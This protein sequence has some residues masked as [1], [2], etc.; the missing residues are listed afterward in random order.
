MISGGNNEKKILRWWRRRRW[1]RHIA[2]HCYVVGA[3]VL[4]PV[5]SIV[6]LAAPRIHILVVTSANAG[7]VLLSMCLSSVR[8][9]EFRA[10]ARFP[11]TVG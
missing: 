2:A 10:T 7:P 9:I 6:A 4:I 1:G 11:A 3:A 5:A 8:C